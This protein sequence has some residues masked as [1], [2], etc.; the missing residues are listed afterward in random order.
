[1]SQTRTDS[2]ELY[3]RLRNE[4]QEI[5]IVDAHDHLPPEEQWLGQEADF[6]S[7]L[8]YAGL[9][10]VY[11]GMPADELAPGLSAV[12]KWERA[13]PYWRHVRNTGG[14]A[15]CRRALALYC[16]VDDL[17]DAAIPIIQD[18]L[19][20]LRKPGLY[21][22]LFREKHNIAVCVNHDFTSPIAVPSS[23]EFF[24]PLLYTSNYS[25]VQTRNDVHALEVASGRDI[26][27]LKT[28]LQALDSV[29]E[30]GVQNGIVGLKWHRL[31]YLR[32]MHYP[33]E[34]PHV[35]EKC[36]GRILQMPAREGSAGDTPVGFDEMIPFQNLIQHHLVQRAIELDLAVQ[37]HTGTLGGSYGAQISHT[38]P[39]HLVNLFLQYPQ[40][41]FN[42]LHASYPY[43]RELGALV[44]LF[45]NVY[46]NTAWFEVLSPRAA[47]QFL[48]EWITSIP[49]NKILAF[50]GDHHCVLL[51]CA[52]AELVRDNLAELLATEVSEGHMSEDAALDVARSLLRENAWEHFQLQD[53]WA[54][55]GEAR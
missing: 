15:L 37:I 9:D 36:L 22:R 49:T 35:A 8:G 46:I 21:R 12:E 51:S 39:T 47:K 30:Q 50:G 4:I 52:Y 27:S 34:D 18:K 5:K 16:G 43:M 23:S 6:V 53:R 42:L 40:A 3:K 1:M 7:L 20:A 33:I 48:W 14:G 10:M 26:Y 32:D 31:A 45:P 17:D 29:I 2:D 13:R 38:N 55:R 11:A 54:N 41:R 25:R 44:K 28:Y 19:E 24:A